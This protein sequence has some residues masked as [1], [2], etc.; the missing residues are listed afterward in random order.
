MDFK[1]FT[2]KR[3]WGEF[4]QYTDGGEPVT[5]KTILVN[6]GERLSLQ[7][8]HKREE[9]WTVLSGSPELV[10]G[11]DTIVAKAGDEFTI[12]PEVKH[13]ISAPNDTVTILEISYGEFDENDIVRLE[14][15]YGR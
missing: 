11:D 7:F 10:I 9:F 5:V 15:N 13:R 3:P 6:R 8:H 12:A 4:R 1:P 2:E 14:D